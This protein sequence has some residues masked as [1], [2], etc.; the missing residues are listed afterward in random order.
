[1][2]LLKKGNFKTRLAVFA[3][4]VLLLLDVRLSVYGEKRHKSRLFTMQINIQQR[5]WSYCVK[6]IKLITAWLQIRLIKET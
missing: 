5:L 6:F 2:F 1:M 4:V 3:N